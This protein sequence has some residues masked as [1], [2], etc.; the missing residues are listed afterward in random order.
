VKRPQNL[1]YAPEFP[2]RIRSEVK[3]GRPLVLFHFD[4]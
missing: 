4:H 1:V 3:D 2:D